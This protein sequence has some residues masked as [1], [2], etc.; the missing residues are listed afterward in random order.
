MRARTVCGPWWQIECT[1]RPLK[2]YVVHGMCDEGV[3]V[4]PVYAIME[5]KKREAYEKVLGHYKDRTV[6]FGMHFETLRLV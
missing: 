2:L 4:P 1:I 5:S 3:D 6:C